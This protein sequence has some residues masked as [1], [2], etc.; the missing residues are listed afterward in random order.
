MESQNNSPTINSNIQTDIETIFMEVKLDGTFSFERIIELLHQ[1]FGIDFSIKKAFV[2][3]HK[4]ANYGKLLLAIRTNKDRIILLMNLLNEFYGIRA[5][6][7][8]EPTSNIQK[9]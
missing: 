1:D 2:N 5:N 9:K 3:Y 4:G 7:A 6:T 8:K